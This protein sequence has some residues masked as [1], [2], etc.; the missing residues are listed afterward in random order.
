MVGLSHS[1]GNCQFGELQHLAADD[2]GKFI[3]N[4]K[5]FLKQQI[6]CKGSYTAQIR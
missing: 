6:S 4:G 1:A 3:Y 5:H 2:V